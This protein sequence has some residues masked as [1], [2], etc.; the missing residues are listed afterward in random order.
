[1]RYWQPLTEE[2]AREV[3]AFAPDEVVLL[4]LYPQFSTTTTASSLKAWAQAYPG[5]GRCAPSAAIRQRRPDRGP[6]RGDPRGPGRRPATEPVRLLFSAH[7]LPREGRRRGDPYQAQVEPP[8]PPSPPGCRRW[9][10]RAV[11]YQSRVGP[12]KWLGPST[13]EAIEPAAEDGVG[14][15]RR[16]D[17]LRLRAYRDP[18]RARHRIRRAGPRTWRRPLSAVRRSGSWPALYR[19]PG[20]A[21]GRGRWPR[22]GVAPR[23]A[24]LPRRLEGLSLRPNGSGGMNAYDLRAACTSWP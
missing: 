1:M 23:S 20:R 16:P 7:G 21:V 13:P 10:L 15:D 17:R 14:R 18:G 24:R 4:P 11:C 8:P 9:R 2:T 19:S 3:A 5:P 6:R 22:T 12:M